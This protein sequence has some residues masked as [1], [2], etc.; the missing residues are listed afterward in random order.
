MNMLE[1]SGVPKIVFIDSSVFK[2]P[3]PNGENRE[4]IKQYDFIKSP[5]DS[6]RSEGGVQIEVG[7]KYLFSVQLSWVKASKLLLKALWKACAQPYV[8]F[9]ISD[10]QDVKFKVRV[11]SPKYKYTKGLY[12]LAYDIQVKMTGIEYL[13]EPGYGDLNL[14]GYG[15]DYGNKTGNQSP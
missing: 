12:G 10:G 1:G 8:E 7:T 6:F 3:H 14:D 2:L 15:S 13:N 11:D 5:L 4:G 9:Y